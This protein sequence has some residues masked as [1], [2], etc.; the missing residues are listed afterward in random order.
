M[1]DGTRKQ[2]TAVDNPEDHEVNSHEVTGSY[3]MINQ[4]LTYCTHH[5][6]NNS[7]DAVKNVISKFYDADEIVHAMEQLRWG[8]AWV[9]A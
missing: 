5:L 7:V 9:L 2:S 6:N 1:A 3:V 8:P 4:L